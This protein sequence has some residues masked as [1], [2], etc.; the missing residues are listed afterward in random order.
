M[1]V[2]LKAG[3]A[4][5]GRMLGKGK[6]N[7]ARGQT[8]LPTGVAQQLTG[9]RHATVQLMTSNAGCLTGTVTNVRE[10]SGLTFKG[11]TP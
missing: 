5:N 8:A 11:T 9:D 4:S 3:I 7:L 10:A 6:N 2:L 1:Q